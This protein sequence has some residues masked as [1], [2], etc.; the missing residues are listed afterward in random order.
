MERVTEQERVGNQIN[1]IIE[2]AESMLYMLED[3]ID[4]SEYPDVEEIV[5][6]YISGV[7]RNIKWWRK[8][9]NEYE[10][11]G[12]EREGDYSAKALNVKI[13]LGFDRISDTY[14]EFEY[15]LQ[16]LGMY[17]DFQSFLMQNFIEFEREN[18]F[19]ETECDVPDHSYLIPYTQMIEKGESYTLSDMI[20]MQ[21]RREIREIEEKLKETVKEQYK[22]QFK[23][24]SDEAEIKAEALSFKCNFLKSAI[25][26]RRNVLKNKS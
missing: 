10:R 21:I 17:A 25:E 20:N 23:R 8:L 12:L 7:Q 4:Y 22:A 11:R 14:V 13:K 9:Q 16:Q 15:E 3:Y 24:G 1:E 26:I 19:T 6:K 2:T 18:G 5:N